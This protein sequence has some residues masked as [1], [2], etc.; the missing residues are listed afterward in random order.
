MRLPIPLPVRGP[1][2]LLLTLGLCAATAA[3]ED[4]IE[5]IYIVC[6]SGIPT[7]VR[8]AKTDDVVKPV[9]AGTKDGAVADAATDAAV[10]AGPADAGPGNPL[11]VPFP[12]TGAPITAPLGAWTFVQFMDTQCRDGSPAGIAVN[13]NPSSKKVMIFLEGGG[14]CFDYVSCSRSAGNIGSRGR[15]MSDGVFDRG[16]LVNP[17]RDW[18]YVYVPYCTGDIHG[19]TNATGRVQNVSGTQRFVGHL[20]MQRFLQR[21][22]PTFRDASDLLLTGVSAGGYGA[23]LNGILVQRAFP[24]VKVKL[25]SDSAPPLPI[26]TAP[27]CLQKKWSTTWGFDKSLFADCG[28]NCPNHEDY[29]QTY[30]LYVNQLLAD[31]TSGFLAA[32]RDNV[33]ASFYGAG[34]DD[35]TGT[36][37]TDYIP[38]NV[39]ARDVVAF[40]DRAKVFGNHGTYLLDSTSHGFLDE[41]RFFS[42]NVGEV[43][44][45]DWFTKIVNNQPAGHVGP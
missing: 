35:C 26:A 3:C 37:L 22:G 19:G 8:D 43:K 20:T 10:D 1:S 4:T 36:T 18:N 6:D 16:N 15:A 28:T 30:A 11:S 31:R 34:V 21:L 40:R 2:A 25:V 27:A 9:D 38:L 41:D 7:E 32:T 14:A 45:I 24:Q 12:T 13:L 23:L 33:I 5:N 42:T 44:L 17:V 29:A 39:L